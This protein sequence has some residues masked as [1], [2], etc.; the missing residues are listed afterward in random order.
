MRRIGKVMIERSQTLYPLAGRKPFPCISLIGWL[1]MAV[2]L[3]AGAQNLGLN[4]RGDVGLKSGTQPIPG[5]YIVAPLYWRADYD[6]LRGPNGNSLP[7]D[8]NAA[9]NLIAP[10]FAMVTPWKV[11][12]ATYG[13]Q[14]V[15]PFVNQRLSVASGTIQ[16]SNGYGFGDMY[17]QPVSLGW[18]TK[19]ADFLAAYGFYAPTGSGNRTLDMWSNELVGGTTVYLDEKKNWTVAGTMFYDINS[20]KRSTDVTVGNFL[21]IEGGAGRSFLKGAG[22]AGLAYVL[23]WKTTNDSGSGLSPLLPIAKSHAYAL[24]PELNVP[25]FAKGSMVGI[26][27]FRYTFEVGNTYNF[28]GRNLVLSLTLAKLNLKAAATH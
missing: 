2:C 8:N 26:F 28:Q 23:Q 16:K 25:F 20:P 27:G 5:Y 10:A 6:S 22:S 18:H 3:P 14:I 17:V 19:H 21:T 4:L 11:L 7:F 15:P 1:L 24:G 13:F 9:I 12:G